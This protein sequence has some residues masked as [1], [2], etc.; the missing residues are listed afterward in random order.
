M[1]TFTVK[2]KGIMNAEKDVTEKVT[3]KFDFSDST[4]DIADAVIEV[5][6]YSGTA[7]NTPINL[8]RGT[9]TISGSK[10]Y[11]AIHNGVVGTVYHVICRATTGDGSVYLLYG[12][13]T[14]TQI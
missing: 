14:I 10:V 11:Q 8:I 1:E 4:Q 12:T 6:R 13:I 9:R 2:E 5:K 3:I 7:D